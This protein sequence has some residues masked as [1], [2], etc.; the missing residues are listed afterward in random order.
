MPTQRT[1]LVI[2]G[3]GA[4]RGALTQRLRRLGYRT[5]RAK[6]PEQAFQL[7]GE[8]HQQVAA[9]LIPPDLAVIDLAAALAALAAGAPDG[10]LS[11]IVAGAGPGPEALSELRAAG[12]AL[13]LW[14]PF[15]D[16]RLR[17]Q[18]NRALA[19]FWDHPQRREPR[20]PIDAPAL[21]FHAGRQKGARLYTLS[22]GGLFLETTR[23]AVR[24]AA[25]EVEIPVGPGSLRLPGSVL[26]TNVPGN[27]HRADLPVG[28][29]VA[30]GAVAE[31]ALAAIRREVAQVSLGLTL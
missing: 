21:F 8:R 11:Y 10:I 23:P 13:A 15:D 17:F 3:G 14:E 31:P 25:V 20:A 4:P 28:M 5:L 27:L 19:R 26:Y 16:A 29:G 12:L 30:F 7:V 22:A 9:A 24:N 2:D 18:V 1:V 6:S